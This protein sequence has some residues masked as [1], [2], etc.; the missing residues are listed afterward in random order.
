MIKPIP[1]RITGDDFYLRRWEVQDAA[2]YV[3]ARDEEIF[4]WTTNVSEWA[5][6]SLGVER[7]RLKM[8]PGNLRSRGVAERAGFRQMEAGGEYALFEREKPEASLSDRLQSQNLPGMRQSRNTQE[9]KRL[10]NT[11]DV[12][13]SERKHWHREYWLT[14]VISTQHRDKNDYIGYQTYFSIKIDSP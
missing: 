7:I 14:I 4:R 12:K 6:R 13:R 10:W 9:V 1:E 11:K 3:H 5:F 8:L 2:W